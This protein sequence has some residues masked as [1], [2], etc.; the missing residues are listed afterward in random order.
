MTFIAFAENFL[1][2]YKDDHRQIL[3]RT[4]QKNF[5]TPFYG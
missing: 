4:F 2:V 1:P 3:I 5:M